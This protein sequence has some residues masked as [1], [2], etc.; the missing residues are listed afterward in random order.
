MYATIL[1]DVEDEA[2]LESEGNV[3]EMD[4]KERQKR[5]RAKFFKC[6]ETMTYA[7]FEPGLQ[8]SWPKQ[9]YHE[10][11]YIQAQILNSLAMLS[12]LPDGETSQT[13]MMEKESKVFLQLG[14]LLTRETLRDEQFAIYATANASLIHLTVGLNQM[15]R[16]IVS[17]VGEK[18][19][20]AF[21][22][23]QER[24]GREDVDLV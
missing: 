14:E 7:A 8:G 4:M 23:A 13:I 15:Y 22:R 18:E 2:A 21:D 3:L 12:G 9:T 17:L 16:L 10:L 5:Y 19:L 20:G 11:L 1:T 6:I 24:S